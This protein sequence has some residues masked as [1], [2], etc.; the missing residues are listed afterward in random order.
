MAKKELVDDFLNLRAQGLSY[1][2]IQVRIGVSKTTQVKWSKEHRGILDRMRGEELEQ[3]AEKLLL[4]RIQRV[5]RFA[6]QLL[7]IET[8]LS[9]RDLSAVETKDLLAAFVRVLHYVGKAVDP[10]EPEAMGTAQRY[11]DIITKIVD[12]VPDGLPGVVVEVE[13]GF[14]RS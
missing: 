10:L 4:T 14:P 2:A 13:K 6:A 7:R 9:A 11:A 12:V 5:R 3:V 8:E 1:S